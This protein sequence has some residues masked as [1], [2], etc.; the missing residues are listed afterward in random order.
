ML[1]C[2]FKVG[3]FAFHKHFSICMKKIAYSHFIASFECHSSEEME[4]ALEEVKDKK[5]SWFSKDTTVVASFLTLGTLN[6]VAVIFLLARKSKGQDGISHYFNH[7]YIL[8]SMA[9]LGKAMCLIPYL[10]KKY[11]GSYIKGEKRN[12]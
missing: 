9:F 6:S 10:I 3:T 8:T 7:P 1:R 4:E 12:V 11:S 5:K 2:T